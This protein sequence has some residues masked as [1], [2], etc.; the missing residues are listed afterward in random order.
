MWQHSTVLGCAMYSMGIKVAGF[1]QMSG[2]WQCA[3]QKSRRSEPT[4]ASFGM[5]PDPLERGSN[6]ICLAGKKIP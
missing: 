1:C 6:Y 5:K 2:L 4:T 3:L